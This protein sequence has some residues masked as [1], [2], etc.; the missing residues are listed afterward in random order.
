MLV[1]PQKLQMGD[2]VGV[3]SPA[4]P[5]DPD[6]LLRGIAY[7]ENLGLR[8]KLG[9]NVYKENGYLA[10]QDQERLD[11]LHSMFADCDVKAIICARGGYGTSRIA[12]QINY[13]L[14]ANNPKIFWGYSDITFL[15]T[16]FRQR[17][18]LVT[19][20]GPML[21]SDIGKDEWDK[22]SAHYFEQMFLTEDIVYDES[23]APIGT[24]IKGYV[25]G[26]LVGGNLCL[27][28]TTLGTPFEIETKDK[29]IFI[30]DIHEEP[31]SIDRYLNQLLMA[32]KFDNIGGLV[33]GDFN[34]CGPGE[35]VQTF[36][37]DEVLDYYIKLINKPTLKGLKIGHCSPNVSIPLGTKA[38]ICTDRKQLIIESGVSD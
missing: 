26:E 28:N 33:I 9:K 17:S 21:S 6:S 29:I 14:I 11:D 38:I 4:S 19:F 10:G 8:V 20:H 24:P 16:A 22:L 18:K 5:S 13:E 36:S 7:L 37:L 3:I 32:G 12:S 30:E 1:K 31:R 15:H 25:E 34:E 35:R 2:T 27:L 23:I